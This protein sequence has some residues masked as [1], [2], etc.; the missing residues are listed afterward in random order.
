MVTFD[1]LKKDAPKRPLRKRDGEIVPAIKQGPT[2]TLEV[3]SAPPTTMRIR[4]LRDIRGSRSGSFYQGQSA[5]LPLATA[6][7]WIQ[8][9][10][11]EEDKMV[12]SAKETK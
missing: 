6:L 1:D 7:S 3:V 8:I 9:G 2:V 5:T 4:M 11:A 10:F 12:D